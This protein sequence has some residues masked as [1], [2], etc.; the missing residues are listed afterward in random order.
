MNKKTLFLILTPF[1]LA[2]YTTSAMRPPFNQN[3]QN[4]GYAGARYPGNRVEGMS[5]G[6]PMSQNNADYLTIDPESTRIQP[7]QQ[8]MPQRPTDI[9]AAAHEFL[10]MFLTQLESM[11]NEIGLKK[12]YKELAQKIIEQLTKAGI[13]QTPHSQKSDHYSPESPTTSRR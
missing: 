8:P 5:Q 1:I 6:Q 10:S 12:E 4:P 11:S 9:N 13:R 3:Q 7:I 2:A